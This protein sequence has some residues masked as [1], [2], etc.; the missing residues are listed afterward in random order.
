[1]A[2]GKPAWR[3]AAVAMLVFQATMGIHD[4]LH[5][6]AREHWNPYLRISPL[7]PLWSVALPVTWALVLAMVGMPRPSTERPREP[8]T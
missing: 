6:G 1:L 8:A 5:R 4:W 2:F 7:R 3:W